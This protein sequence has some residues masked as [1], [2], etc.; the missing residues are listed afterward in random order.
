MRELKQ[1][2]WL[3]AFMFVLLVAKLIIVPVLNWQE[4][5]LADIRLLEKKQHKIAS[6]LARN[7]KNKQL[8]TELSAVLKKTTRI[9]F[10]YQKETDFKLT[11]QKLLETLLTKHNLTI[12]NIGWQAPLVFEELFAKRYEI[13]IRVNGKI[14][15][16]VEFMATLEANPQYIDISHFNLIVKKKKNEVVGDAN[17][18]FNLYLYS[19]TEQGVL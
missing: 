10:P 5:K 12:K 19:K 18:R 11:Q 14:T 17:G 3:L 8:N 2:A 15:D 9:F 4:D 13:Q 16:I 1:H 7:N 6:V